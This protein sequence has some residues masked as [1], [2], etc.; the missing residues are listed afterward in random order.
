MGAT[1]EILVHVAVLSLFVFLFLAMARGRHDD[2]LRCWV[3]G[4][5]SIVLHFAVDLWQPGTQVWQSVQSCLSV[6]ALALAA[7]CFV[8]STMVQQEGRRNGRQLFVLL[9]VTT[10]FCLN[11]AITGE[12]DVWEL[13]AAVAVRQGTAM[14]LAAR[15][16]RSRAVAAA[17]VG[18]V[19]V[20]TG[21]WMTYGILHGHMEVVV[22]A[23]LGEMYVVTAID[24]YVNGW[25]RTVAIKTMIAGLTAWGAVFPVSYLLNQYWPHL[26]INPEVWNVPKFCVAVGMILAVM[27][28][29]NRVAEA[30]NEDYRLL[31]NSN[32]QALWILET[33]ALRFLAVNETALELHGYRREE[34]LNLTLL[35][36]VHADLH[37]DV[38]EHVQTTKL[39]SHMS[40]RHTRKDGS[41]LPLDVT[42]YDIVFEGKPCRFVMAVDATQREALA[43]ELNHKTNFDELTELPNRKTFPD[44]LARA[45]HHALTTGEKFA[46]IS[47]DFDRFKRVNEMYGLRA[48]DEFIQRVAEILTVRMRSMDIVARTAGDEFTI[49][50]TGLKSKESAEQ[51]VNELLDVF[52]EPLLVQ[53]YR[54]QRPVCIGVSLGP[55]NRED[56]NAL[57]RGAESARNQAKAAGGG[58]AVWLSEE[59]DRA[60][61][62]QVEIERYIR[63]NLDDGGF[64][65]L[66]Q[67]LYG[68]DGRVHSL[69]ALMR[70][71]HPTLGMVS[72]VRVIPIAEES[73]LIL[74]LGQWAIEEVCRQLLVWRSQ[75][76][77]LVPVAVNVSGLQIMHMDFARRLMATLNRYEIEPRLMRIE[78]T[79]SVAMR[80]VTDVSDQMA[81]LAAMGIAFSIDDF[82]TGH[83]SL[84]RLS[85]LG[86]S[87][88]KIDR[89]F[90]APTSHGNAQ[91]IVQAI[92][93]MAHAL[94]H[95]VVAEGVETAEQVTSLR[96]LHCDLLQGFLLSR[97]APPEQIP[98]LLAAP[99]AALAPAE[100]PAAERLRLVARS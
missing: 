81:A 56:P 47:L 53:G 22:A 92:I 45:A 64:H 80:N 28:E 10:L 23:V 12:H 59:L 50:L 78:V 44:L 8:V 76:V 29:D 25:K 20:A 26:S 39:S 69:E 90:L 4:W 86:T 52:S 60:A 24:F 84:A 85:E 89:S 99:N 55:D 97:P 96:D 19:C 34:F 35:D 87:E 82:G 77:S 63:S 73:G 88:L 51:T 71:K 95:T 49:V 16:R 93:T 72:P 58:I 91:S 14:A 42:A 31:F 62:E 1:Q 37:Q 33:A 83:S 11:V 2:R 7:L 67:P 43:L 18:A 38:L 30:R 36:V 6:D 74:Q 94:G 98:A 32:P 41:I 15:M 79:E 65:L 66:Y 27:E 100:E 40:S 48:G 57:W 75:G 21:V 68:M 46:V 17:V 13:V 9:G 5:I 3:A 61:R 70:L 54:I